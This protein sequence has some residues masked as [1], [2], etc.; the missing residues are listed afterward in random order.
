[1][2]ALL[3][4]SAFVM[5]RSGEQQV[6][7]SDISTEH[8]LVFFSAPWCGYCDRARDWFDAQRLDYLEIDIEGSTDANR[9]WRDAG[10]RGVPHVLIGE[11]RIPGYSP[12]AYARALRA[13]AN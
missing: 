4:L 10:G 3:G 2:A 12:E 5:W 6:T 1:M 13:A 8:E 11:Q 9:L 7:A